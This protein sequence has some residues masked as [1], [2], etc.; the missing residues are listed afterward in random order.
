MSTKPNDETGLT[1]VRN[2]VAVAIFMGFQNA[3]HTAIHN[4]TLKQEGLLPLL[5]SA[6]VD[7]VALLRG[8]P[9]PVQF[10]EGQFLTLD[11]PEAESAQSIFDQMES[12]AVEGAM[13]IPQGAIVPEKKVV[14]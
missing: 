13:A 9:V 8:Q 12:E 6:G 2:K 1:P 11:S 14:N 4:G 3:V 5:A 7:A 10:H